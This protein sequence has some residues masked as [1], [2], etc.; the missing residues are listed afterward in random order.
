MKK[1]LSNEETNAV[2]NGRPI[3]KLNDKNNEL[4]EVDL[5]KAQI[6]HKEPIVGCFILQ[7]AKCRNYA[8]FLNQFL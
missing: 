6:E 1:D 2:F 7:Y 3:K 8:T 4:Y 5:V